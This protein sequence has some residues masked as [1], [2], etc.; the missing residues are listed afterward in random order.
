M[1][2]TPNDHSS[3]FAS[4]LN[5]DKSKNLND[6]REKVVLNDECGDSLWDDVLAQ[7]DRGLP[8]EEIHK[9]ED[10]TNDADN[11]Q[12]CDASKV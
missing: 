5:N 8:T 1:E 10:A 2:T 11:V 12:E 7:E 9:E 3:G 4:F 6:R